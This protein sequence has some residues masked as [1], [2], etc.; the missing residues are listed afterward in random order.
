VGVR[1][2]AVTVVAWASVAHADPTHKLRLATLVPEGTTWARELHA[3]EREVAHASDG[4]LE[5]KIFLGGI[6]GD[7]MQVAD[8]IAREQLDGIGS[9]GMLC[10][11]MIP[12]MRVM[13][14]PGLFQTRAEAVHVLGALREQMAAEARSNGYELL[15]TSGL[16][17]V[18]L[19]S[20][21]PVRTLDELRALK[22]WVW[23]LDLF[24]EGMRQM[25]L[26][27]V[28]TPLTDALRAYDEG[29]LD[30]FW[31]VPTA[32]LSFQWSAR[33]RYLTELRTRYLSACLLISAR[34]FDRL[35]YPE[36]QILRAAAARLDRRFEGV[37]SDW[38]A[39][40]LGGL[41]QKQ[42]LTMVP[43]SE[44]LRSQFLSLAAKSRARLDP[45]QFPTDTIEKV[46]TLLADYRAEHGSR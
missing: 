33:A 31:A 34:A 46:L 9:G 22:A 37:Q 20:R 13:A 29:K 38:D 30:G 4:H 24:V 43:P 19:F 17:P 27:V 2:L 21:T 26:P 32:A 35:S 14:V 5:T 36:Q 41:F 7:E 44:V 16:G 12:T 1:G 6:A 45:K 15:G 42:G 3:F 11:R 25:G 10:Q 8:R 40:L 39:Q 23:D 18:I 28:P